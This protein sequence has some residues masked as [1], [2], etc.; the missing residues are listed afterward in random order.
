MAEQFAPF[1]RFYRECIANIAQR[2]AALGGLRDGIDAAYATDVLWLY[3]G[4]GSLYTLRH[5]NGW[6]YSRAQTW[7]AD[8]AA[9]ELLSPPTA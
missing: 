1:T 5:E 7:L 8:Q 6:S 4:Y 2:L 9:R 3:F